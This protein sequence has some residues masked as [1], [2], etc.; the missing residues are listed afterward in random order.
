LSAIEASTSARQ[1][2]VQQVQQ[3]D[4]QFSHNYFA[5]V[6]NAFDEMNVTAK[7]ELKRV[8]D[9]HVNNFLDSKFAI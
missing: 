7:M 2:P 3:V 4:D 5:S 1:S 8:I 6:R 9:E